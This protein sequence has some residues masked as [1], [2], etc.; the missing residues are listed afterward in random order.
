[1]HRVK[2]LSEKGASAKM[3]PAVFLLILAGGLQ[4]C[5]TMAA[6]ERNPAFSVREGILASDFGDGLSDRDRAKAVQAEVKALTQNRPGLTL[7]WQGEDG[8]RGKVTPD[9]I[10]RI[11]DRICRRYLHELFVRGEIR[12]AA[13]T[14]CQD[15]SANWLPV[16]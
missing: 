3:R 13:G 8:V 11:G 14:A 10:F 6:L 12:R 7:E 1:M 5:A 15:S 4:G 16:S 9:Q 2:K